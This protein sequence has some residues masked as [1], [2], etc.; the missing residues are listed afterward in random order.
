M[1]DYGYTDL[2]FLAKLDNAET[3]A[4]AQKSEPDL[5]RAQGN[6]I[7]VW[8]RREILVSKSAFGDFFLNREGNKVIYYLGIKE[9]S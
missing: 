3:N 1:G 6:L 2:G 4:E 7:G 5:K 9:Y 8:S